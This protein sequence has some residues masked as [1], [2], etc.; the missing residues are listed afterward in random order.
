MLGKFR[1]AD[2]LFRREVDTDRQEG[3]TELA[4]AVAIEQA[5]MER[6]VGETA[7]ARATLNQLGKQVQGDPDFALQHTLLGDVAFAER[8]LAAHSKDV[9][10]DTGIFHR[11]IPQLRAALAMHRKAPLDAVAAL[12]PPN[13][14]DWPH[15]SV[16]TERGQAYMEAGQPA[17]AAK[18]FQFIVD[19]PGSFFA[20]DRPLAR[21]GL[22]RAYAAQLDK[23]AARK[24]YETFLAAWKDADPDVPVLVAAKAELARLR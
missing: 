1:Q 14:L 15:V 10:P 3:L 16:L 23:P 9:H 19:H 18:D 4:D 13:T 2:A 17:L 12:Q 22:A 8:Y 7:A 21:L 24:E 11:E 6:E 20:I 5:E